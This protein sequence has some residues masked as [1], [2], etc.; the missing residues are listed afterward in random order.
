MKIDVLPPDV[1]ASGTD[2]T[3]D[4]DKIRFGL[5]AIKNVGLN[6]VKTIIETK[7]KSGPYKSFADFCQRL[8]TTVI[9]RRVLENL[10][11]SGALDS[12]GHNRSQMMAAIDAGLGLAQ[13]TK[14]DQKN[15]QLS[16][17]DFWG[18]EVKDTLSLDMPIIKEFSPGELLALEKEALGLYVS[19]HPLSEY[20]EAIMCHATHQV[21]SLTELEE[22]SDVVVGGLLTMLKK[23]VTKRG[24]SMAFANLEDLTGTV[25]LVVFPRTYQQ[26]AA[27]LKVDNPV[28]VRGVA[29]LK[30]EQVKIIVSAL[31]PIILQRTGELY[32]KMDDTSPEIL[33]KIQMVLRS[34]PGECPVFLYFPL[35]KSWP[36]PIAVIGSTWTPTCWRNLQFYWVRTGSRSKNSRQPPL[37]LHKPLQGR[38]PMPLPALI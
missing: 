8:D 13:L 31:E 16:L 15:G 25:E 5:A 18:D 38:N 7:E 32:I 4:G 29:E 2:F 14:Q 36:G 22:R 1:N 19:G 24:D 37:V 30:D 9:N 26:Y 34:F 33:S 21:A 10:I 27:L 20:H 35:E 11:K 6:A 3:V 23:I 12:L 17:L 28:I